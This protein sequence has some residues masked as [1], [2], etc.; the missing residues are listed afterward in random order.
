MWKQASS[1]IALVL[2]ASTVG[3]AAPVLWT[4]SGVT[5]SDGGT[6]TGSFI[7]NADT[8][9][10]SSVH[11]ITSGGTNPGATYITATSGAT[12]DLIALVTAT[13]GDLTGT[14]LVIFVANAPLSNA[15]GTRTLIPNFVE[16]TCNTA[17]CLS[18]TPLRSLTAGTLTASAAPTAT[19]PAVSPV[20]LA[21]LLLLLSVMVWRLLRSAGIPDS[22]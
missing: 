22:M 7:Y 10:Y 5:F 1:M 3:A 20:A 14:P 4:F 2:M 17:A 21:L 11:V 9:T 15:G 8:N 12:A 18:G 6:A 13:A 16:G 19:V